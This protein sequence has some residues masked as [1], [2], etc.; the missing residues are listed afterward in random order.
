M[1]RSIYLILSL[2]ILA[3]ACHKVPI[4]GR[5]QMK[6]LPNSS[7]NSMAVAQYKTFL[8]TNAVSKDAQNTAMVKRVGERI[9]KAVESY[10]AA[11]KQSKYLAGYRWVF[12]LVE[13]KAVNAWCMP[14]GKVVVY[15]GLLPVALNEDGLAVVMG[16]EIAHAIANHG[17]ERM[18]QGLIAQGGGMALS[19]AISQKPKET[20]NL[21][22]QAYGVGAQVGAMLPFSR[23]QESEADEMGLI[24]MAIAGYNP[25]E[26][27]PFWQRMGKASGGGAPPE[28]LSTHPS[29]ATRIAKLKKAIP[30][31][32]LYAKKYG[33]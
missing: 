28:F 17:N 8:G 7:L 22:M 13:D 32:K 19:V 10:F 21:F 27:V 31:A 15:T 23:L 16:H 9:Q 3:T 33:K 18:S 14:G 11:K 30:K 29:N 5:R 12:N 24:F 6:L 26:A 25:E 20:Q 4:T 1:K 2:L